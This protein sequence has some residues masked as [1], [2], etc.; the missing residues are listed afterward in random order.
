M[1]WVP[2][3]L[4][5]VVKWVVF[6]FTVAKYKTTEK[7][8]KCGKDRCR[9]P[10][11]RKPVHGKGRKSRSGQWLIWMRCLTTRRPT[12]RNPLRR[13]FPSLLSARKQ[14]YPMPLYLRG[15]LGINK[16]VEEGKSLEENASPTF[17][18]S[19]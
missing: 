13:G 14:V 8:I 6:L 10:H 12:T 7:Q 15:W 19:R 16:V 3:D 17:W 11:G 5:Q 4:K 18:T 1:K 9:I 2:L